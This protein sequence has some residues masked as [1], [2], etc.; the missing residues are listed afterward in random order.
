MFTAPSSGSVLKPVDVK[1]HLLIVEPL[2][3]VASITTAFGD[4]DAV[5]CNVMDVTTGEDHDGVLWFSGAL[6]GALKGAIGK[7]I[8]GVM[9][10]GVAKPGQSAPW[11]LIDATK[12]PALV[13]QATAYLTQKKASGLSSPAP[14]TPAAAEPAAA[15]QPALDAALAN[16]SAA[17]LTK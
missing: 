2:E 9:G 16:L 1:D 10:T 12:E 13:E 6:V 7:Q 11:I 4:S 3:Y 17:G 8:L 14:A 15:S 5:R